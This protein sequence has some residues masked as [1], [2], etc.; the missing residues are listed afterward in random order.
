[1]RSA[2]VDSTAGGVRAGLTHPATV[3]RWPGIG[4]R[5]VSRLRPNTPSGRSARGGGSP[6]SICLA[7]LFTP[8]TSRSG[9]HCSSWNAGSSGGPSGRAPK[10]RS[11]DRAR[12]PLRRPRA[13]CDRHVGE[14]QQHRGRQRLADGVPDAG[15]ADALSSR[16]R[17]PRRSPPSL[18]ELWSDPGRMRAPAR[19]GGGALGGGAGW[20]WEDVHLG[21]VAVGNRVR[22]D[23]A[24]LGVDRIAQ[25]QLRHPQACQSLSTPP[26]RWRSGPLGVALVRRP[27]PAPSPRENRA[28][29]S[30]NCSAP[31]RPWR[32]Q[33]LLRL[34]CATDPPRRGRGD[35][36]HSPAGRLPHDDDDIGSDGSVGDQLI[37]YF[38]SQSCASSITTSS[39]MSV[40]MSR[41]CRR[42]SRALSRRSFWC[43]AAGSLPHVFPTFPARN[44]RRQKQQCAV[45]AGS[46]IS[47]YGGPPRRRRGILA[48]HCVVVLW[49][50]GGGGM[51]SHRISVPSVPQPVRCASPAPARRQPRAL[52]QP[53][54]DE[55]FAEAAA[56]DVPASSS[57]SVTRPATG[58][59]SWPMSRS[60]IRGHGRAT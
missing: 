45:P 38:L 22:P 5:S 42:C 49:Y 35:S 15:C 39:C 1:M 8:I 18:L 34:R 20:R 19:G 36:R 46:R 48:Y 60:R 44:R 10:A 3:R 6:S 41:S 11:A 12:P 30:A 58:V 40:M 4:I 43:H 53:W 23:I 2:A 56:R 7:S 27:V 29:R 57:R 54:G 55:A 25:Q 16:S 21:G 52:V 9:H 32:C 31:R 14:I 17:N 26:G 33:Q 59:M 50:G 37:E 51:R 28:I 24:D 47:K 13:G